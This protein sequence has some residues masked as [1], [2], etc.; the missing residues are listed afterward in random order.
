MAAKKRTTRRA[1]GD[2][3]YWYDDKTK[4]HRYRLTWGGQSHTVSDTDRS[5]AE[6]KLTDL[7]RQRDKQIDRAGAAQTLRDFL[8]YWLEH[9]VRRDVKASTYHDYKK[10]CELYITPTLGDMTLGQLEKAPR[11]VRAWSNAVR[12]TFALSSA[13]QALAL[14]KR[15]LDLAVADH[16]I[17]TN[18]AAGVRAPQPNKDEEPQDEE[19]RAMPPS[20]VDRLLTAVKA[21]DARHKTNNYAVYALALRLGLRR[22][23]LL[24]LRWQDIDLAGR[25]VRIRQQVIRLDSEYRVSNTLKTKSSRRDLPMDD[26]T[27]TILAEQRLRVPHSVE[28]V[29]PNERGGFRSP[30][31]LTQHFRRTMER[32]GMAYHLHDLRHTAITRW[33]T[34]GVDLEVASA[35]AGHES[36]AI[37]AN[38]YSAATMERKRKAMEKR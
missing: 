14:L 28:Y 23:E 16:L 33:R 38:I 12:D 24:G 3:T 29:F 25:L 35:L 10:R 6:A 27:H 19:G 36:V 1:K 21:S 13:K 5:R 34:E 2:G 32:L 17:E 26:E 37:T 15:A 7:K 9:D 8:A 4:Q 18:P 22:G 30:N 31:S 11:T 20:D